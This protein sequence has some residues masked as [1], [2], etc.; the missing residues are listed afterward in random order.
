[1]TP[2]STPQA[3]RR[4]AASRTA[5]RKPVTA[6]PVKSLPI[7]SEPRWSD[8]PSFI[9][10]VA[11]MSVALSVSWQLGFFFFLDLNLVALFSVADMLQ[12]SLMFVPVTLI[13]WALG[14]VGSRMRSTE[15]A[16]PSFLRKILFE[17]RNPGRDIKR[18]LI[19]F[20]FFFVFFDFWPLGALVLSFDI[21]FSTIAWLKQKGRLSD[22]T[23]EIVFGGFLILET[24]LLGVTLAQVEVGRTAKDYELTLVS[25]ATT[26]VNLLKT[27]TDAFI[28]TENPHELLI[29]PRSQVASLKRKNVEGPKAIFS[30]RQMLRWAW[31]QVS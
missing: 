6:N 3:K 8:V 19:Y 2:K 12:N 20:T 15:P 10:A 29:L 22:L 17:S 28:M 4:A 26:T 24:F 27:T 25:G 9:A 18:A 30:L 5:L 1:M 14:S 31:D 7:A 16:K 11:A 23:I 13:G 21:Y